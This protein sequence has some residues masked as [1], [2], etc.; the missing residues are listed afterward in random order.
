MSKR[1][2]PTTQKKWAK[3]VNKEIMGKEMQ[4]VLNYPKRVSI[5]LTAR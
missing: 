1:K 4:M 5:S 3:D 2:V